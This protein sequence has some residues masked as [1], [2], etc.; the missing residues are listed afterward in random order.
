MGNFVRFDLNRSTLNTSRNTRIDEFAVLIKF[1]R[2][3][4][5]DHILFFGSVYVDDL[6]GYLAV[7]NYAVWSFNEAVGVNLGVGRKVK[8]E[9][10]VCTFR[11]LNGTDTTVVSRVGVT[12]IEA[13]ALPG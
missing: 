10:D 5:D 12:D 13:G 9:T 4:S 1:R 2:S 3:V 6:I 7:L 11:S 8:Y